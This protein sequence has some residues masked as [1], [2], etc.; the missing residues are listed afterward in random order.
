MQAGPEFVLELVFSTRREDAPVADLRA[1]RSGE[2]L[3]QGDCGGLRRGVGE[4]GLQRSGY[5]NLLVP[6]YP[7]PAIPYL[8]RVPATT[9]RLTP[10]RNAI[11]AICFDSTAFH[12]IGASRVSQWGPP[13]RLR[14]G[15]AHRS[16]EG[17]P[18]GSRPFI[19]QTFHGAWALDHIS[20][21]SRLSRSVS[22]GRQNPRCLYALS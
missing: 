15:R 22:I 17:R 2:R 12:R 5:R 3:Q 18:P 4:G 14:G 19:Y 10:P 1:K 8:A 7:V 16:R 20:S 21:S 11:L 9:R 6:S 13:R